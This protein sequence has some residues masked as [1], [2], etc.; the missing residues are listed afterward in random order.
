MSR[1]SQG[2]D[3]PLKVKLAVYGA[4]LFSNSLSN[5]MNIVVPLWA[6]TLDPRPLTLGLVLGARSFLPLLLA[7]HG[8]AL[9]DRIGTRRVLLFFGMVAIITTPLY[10]AL[11]MIPALIALQMLNGLSAS[12]GWVGAQTLIGQIMK[13]STRQAGRL[14]FFSRIGSV[15]GPP[16]I[17]LVWDFLGPW[18]TFALLALPGIAMWMTARVLPPDPETIAETGAAR[19][20]VRWRDL[21]PRPSDYIEAFRMLAVPAI[22]FVVLIA[23][24]RISGN[25]I[26]SSFY[27]V[28]LEQI[29]MTGTLIGVL[30]SINSLSGGF[31]AL[32]TRAA[33]RI[34]RAP[35]LLFLTV[36]LSIALITI[37]P[38]M[39]SFVVLAIVAS[40]RGAT[41]GMSQPLM[42]S[43]MA[44]SSGSRQGRAVG[45][46]TTTNR[47]IT[48]VVPIA[49][50]GLMEAFGIA[51]SF[52]IT[53]AIVA[54]MMLPALWA[55]RRAG[56][57]QA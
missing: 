8:G 31:S 32:A 29:G 49:M 56:L 14:S 27:V 48:V 30:S 17:G 1:S 13:G 19:P 2:D 23:A 7:I 57:A 24:V 10:P 52:Y 43:I 21:V 42:I 9:M 41:M 35:L 47:L 3:L 40:F 46:R 51:M 16:V 28:Y 18:P 53:G 6:V 54:A 12:M 5:M 44:K 39:T 26:K 36:G 55:M 37:T 33:T 34:M 22:A 45:L 20:P 15:G 38:L 11:P 25:G 4:G 50:G